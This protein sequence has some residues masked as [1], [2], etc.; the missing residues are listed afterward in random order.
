VLTAVSYVVYICGAIYGVTT[1]QIGMNYVNLLPDDT[2]TTEY[3]ID[4]SNYLARTFSP[5]MEVRAID[6]STSR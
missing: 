6:Q 1:M 4:Y 5:P 3:L 2:I